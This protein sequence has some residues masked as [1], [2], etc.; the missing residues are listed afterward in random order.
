MNRIE[1]LSGI[2]SKEIFTLGN[3]PLN[4]GIAR[5]IERLT[6]LAILL[7][8]GSAEVPK[9][10]INKEITLITRGVNKMKGAVNL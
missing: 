1:G 5:E 6:R 2:L 10:V 3:S 4:S 9:A 8:S 7:N